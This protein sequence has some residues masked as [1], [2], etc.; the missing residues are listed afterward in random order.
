MCWRGTFEMRSLYPVD[1][2]LCLVGWACRFKAEARPV[3][4]TRGGVFFLNLSYRV[5]MGGLKDRRIA[6]VFNQ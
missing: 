2:R 1:L 6:W 4:L 3:D 5:E